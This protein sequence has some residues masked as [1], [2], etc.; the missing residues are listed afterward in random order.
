MRPLLSFD[1]LGYHLT[2]ASIDMY[3]KKCGNPNDYDAVYCKKCGTLLESEDETRVIG[4]SARTPAATV[5]VEDYRIRPT[6]KF[7]LLGYLLTAIGAVLLVILLSMLS[8]ST[9]ISVILGLA[10][11]LIPAYFHLRQRMI[12]YTLNDQSIEVDSGLVSRTTR[13]IPISRIQDVTVSTTV[14]QRLLNFGDV[15]IDNASEDGGKVTI[16]NIDSPREYADRLLSHMKRF[17]K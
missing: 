13:N 7:I 1:Q 6:M 9:I 15:S 8:I 11:F 12:S 17:E 10:L 5:N 16:K 4:R 3:C 14:L 2:D